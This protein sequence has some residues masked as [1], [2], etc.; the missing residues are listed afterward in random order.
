[1]NYPTGEAYLLSANGEQVGPALF[2]QLNNEFTIESVGFVKD[3]TEYS[4]K[5]TDAGLVLSKDGND[6]VLSKISLAQAKHIF[7]NTIRKFTDVGSLTASIKKDIMNANSYVPAVEAE[8][9][10]SFTHDEDG[11][12]L[13]LVRVD[14]EGNLYFRSAGEWVVVGEND[15]A[16]TIFDQVMVDIDEDDAEKAIEY[17]DENVSTKDDMNKDELLQFAALAQ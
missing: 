2:E 5:V 7:P 10:V 13:E 4:A 12:V 11:N 3:V 9:T 14:S 16:P 6:L 8:E 1:M 17:Y 15:D